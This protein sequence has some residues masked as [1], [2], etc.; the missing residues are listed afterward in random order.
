MMNPDILLDL[1]NP[2]Q[3]DAVVA[4]DSRLLVLAGAGS[5]KTRVLVH[6]IAWLVTQEYISPHA[7]LAVTFTNKAAREMRGRLEELL[8]RPVG[9]MW[10]GTFHGIAHRLLRRHWQ[11][12][13]LVEGF[14]IMDSD[15][16]VRLVK[17]I[18]REQELDEKRWPARQAAGFIN[19][20]KDDGLRARHVEAGHDLFRQTMLRIYTAYEERCQKSGLVD[21]NE[22]LLRALELLRD[23]SELL[24]HYQRRFR[25]LLVD[26][27]Q[28]TNAIQYAWLKLLACDDNGVTV[29]GD[30]D[31]S[32]YGW[33]GAKVENLQLLGQDF[34]TL[35]TIR[36]EQNY[37]STSNILKAA[38]AVISHNA[39]RL[40]KTLWTEGK[41][42]E[43]LHSYA[44]FNEVDEAR[45]I[46]GRIQ[47]WLDS[48]QA[49]SDVAILYR[50]NAQ[51]RVLEEAL[52]QCGISY[53]IYGGQRFFQRQE[54]KHALAYLQL[55]NR[56]ESDAAM[57]RVINVPARG[58][59][60]KT[61]TL[62][63][64]EARQRGLPLW[65]AASELVAGQQLSGRAASAVGRFLELIGELQIACKDKPL[66]EQ[67]RIVIHQSGLWEK[68][69]REDQ[70]KHTDRCE[71][72]KELIGA[73]R[74]FE[75]DEADE[76]EG[77]DPL[78][79]FLDQVSLDAGDRDDDEGDAVQMMTLHSAKGLEFPLVFL[80][81]MEEGLFPHQLSADD[82]QRLQEERRLCYV[83]I[84]RAMH[85]LYLTYA[86]SRRLWGV[87][88]SMRMPS[89]FLRELPSE[90]VEEVRATRN[91]AS[92]R[93]KPSPRL[94]EK[95]E[96]D[97]FCLGMRVKHARFGEGTLLR[98]EGLGS[99]ARMQ[100]NFDTVG[101]K[102]LVQ[103]YAKV[104]PA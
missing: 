34:P 29:V 33:R 39:D 40:G 41:D 67:T 55:I 20:C 13:G 58:I 68:Y 52:L 72:L 48:G 8:A 89:R 99:N 82:P 27:F 53:R 42:G 51:S 70:S 46:T 45:F 25:H 102:W 10:V 103:Q 79:L 9:G 12:A 91:T 37:R 61:L 24:Q 83:G 85:S 97:G 15:D 16:Q 21:F 63:R 73:T 86:E 35:R 54:I 18:L 6:R 84:T 36:L 101:S 2:A 98:I 81:G 76:S 3:R 28:D 104:E 17:R 38:N 11:E 59:G 50:S 80:A 23:N 32:I 56:P 87:T 4:D 66:S 43:P 47:A 94:S 93:N 31:Q 60:Q 64:D 92:L 22:L 90:L 71:T 95:T 78:T 19:R 62:I 69:Q 74:E 49:A 75:P 26:E 44:A 100:I 5:G 14:Q 57:E 88:D 7:I 65:R 96:L 30:D 1:L 77:L